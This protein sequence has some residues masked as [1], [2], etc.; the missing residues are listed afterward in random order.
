ML[1]SGTRPRAARAKHCKDGLRGPVGISMSENQNPS[2]SLLRPLRILEIGG[3]SLFALAVPAQTDFCWTGQKPRQHAKS[4]LGPFRFIR[5]LRALRRGEYDLVVVH[6][7][8]YAPWHPR[9]FLTTLRDWHIRAP[10]GF[11]AIWAWR[12]IH[13]FHQVPIVG[14]DLGDSCLIPRHN[15]FLLKACKA[16]FKRELPSDHWLVFCKSS[17]PNFPSRSWRRKPRYNRMIEKL[18]PL[19][20]GSLAV[21]L[22]IFSPRPIE[23]LPDKSVDIFFAGSIA[24]NSTVRIAG[25]RE[26]EVLQREGYVVDVVDKPLP[27]QEFMER[28]SRAWLGWSPGGFGWDCSRHYEVPIAGTVP[29]INYP[30]IERD[31]PLRD[32]EHCVLYSVESGGLAMAARAALSDKSRLREMARTAATHVSTHHTP[33]ARAER[34]TMLVLG[35]R[36]DGRS[37]Q[38]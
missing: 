11:F 2:E 6:A 29:L 15:F 9:T 33:Y 20:Y 25:R 19:S 31:A 10:L 3:D 28:I 38:L 1:S 13:L 34:V 23:L 21:D 36:L 4:A 35:R 12:F 37:S 24:A 17:Y 8:Q 14:I 7:T 26:L 18:K 5:I 27:A 30:A 22:G 32:G 16:F